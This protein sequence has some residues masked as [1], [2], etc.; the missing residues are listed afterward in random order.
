M[1]AVWLA[2][3]LLLQV[4]ATAMADTKARRAEQLYD[5]GARFYNLA[6]Y[7]QAIDAFQQAYLLSGQTSLLFNIAQAARQANRCAEATTAY[8]NYLRAEPDAANRDTVERH[9]AE[10]EACTEAAARLTTP[11]PAPPPTVAATPRPAVEPPPASVSPWVW[12]LGAGGIALAAGGTALLVSTSSSLDACS[13]RCSPDRVDDLRVRAGVGYGLLGGAGLSLAAAA[14]LWLRPPG[15]DNE[16]P[17]VT[18]SL[19][20]RGIAVWSSF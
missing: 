10:M 20:P 13:P 5:E 6:Q 9:I 2:C 18:V 3:V 14:W 8:R 19:H 17:P 16:Q 7:D 4:A 15:R 12:G 11:P 1:K